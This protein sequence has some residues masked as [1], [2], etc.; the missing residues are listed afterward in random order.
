MP[1][2]ESLDGAENSAGATWADLPGG[3]TARPYV[4][5]LSLVNG[6]VTTPVIAGAGVTPPAAATGGVTAVV[7]PVDLCRA[8]D[9]PSP[10]HCYATPNRVGITLAYVDGPNEN[11]DF[12]NPTTPLAATGNAD[13]IVDKTI[14]LNTLGRNL[15]WSW[16]SGQLLSWQ[17]TVLGTPEATLHVKF[18]PTVSPGTRGPTRL[19]RT[20]RGRR[21]RTAA[22][23]CWSPWTGSR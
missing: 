20:H 21:P 3:V 10:G 16:V 19:R 5:S 4:R 13:T 18:H 17:P 6:G 8:G 15:R 12:S 2:Q 9:A 23:V 22:T 1:S 7:A 11:Y 14:A